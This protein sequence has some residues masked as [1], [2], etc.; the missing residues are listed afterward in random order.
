MA[1]VFAVLGYGIS[2]PACYLLDGEAAD[3]Q[4][5]RPRSVMAIETQRLLNLNKL[6]VGMTLGGAVL[7]TVVA[8][9]TFVLYALKKKAIAED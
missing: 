8:Q 9:T 6:R 7:G 4:F 5:T 1:F 2:I 3:F